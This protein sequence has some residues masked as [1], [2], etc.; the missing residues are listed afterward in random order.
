[1]GVTVLQ[2][3]PLTAAE[4][5]GSA[6]MVLVNEIMAREEWSSQSAIGK[7]IRIGFDPNLPPSPIAP[8]TLPC[9]EVVGIVRNS[10]ARSLRPVGREATQM[11]YYVPFEQLP[12]GP[13]GDMAEVN[14]I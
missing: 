5:E 8:A 12:P 2:G 11:Q 7:C 14:G 4:R 9:R 13:F 10:R 1:M 3:R 6:L